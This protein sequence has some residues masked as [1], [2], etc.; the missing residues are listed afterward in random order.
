MF[1]N[2][3]ITTNKIHHSL[4]WYFSYSTVV[5]FGIMV[6]DEILIYNED[7]NKNLSLSD[8]YLRA[9]GSSCGSKHASAR[10]IK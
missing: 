7:I 2:I 6:N 4:S 1:F 3:Q 10:N 9:W 5:S 8:A